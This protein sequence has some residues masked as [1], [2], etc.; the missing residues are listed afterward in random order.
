MIDGSV[1]EGGR[2][3]NRVVRALL[4]SICTN[5]L[6]MPTLGANCLSLDSY[7]AIIIKAVTWHYHKRQAAQGRFSLSR[8]SSLSSGV[9]DMTSTTAAAA[10]AQEIHVSSSYLGLLSAL[11]DERELSPRPQ[12]SRTLQGEQ[13]MPIRLASVDEE[14]GIPDTNWGGRYAHALPKLYIIV[15][16]IDGA[17]LQSV[18]SQRVLAALTEC[19]AISLIASADK[20]NAT[21]L[22]SNEMLDQYRWY[23]VHTPT[24]E[25]YELSRDFALLHGNKGTMHIQASSVETILN[26]LTMRHKE[27]FTLL[28]KE[29]LK[30]GQDNHNSRGVPFD[31]LLDQAM[32]AMLVNTSFG[33][34][35]YLK[36]FADHKV[37]MKSI[38]SNKREW[39]RITLPRTT[40][41]QMLQS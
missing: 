11:A 9:D 3:G 1:K 7:V 40:I 29:S 12:D 24:Y 23:F 19:P 35:N 13:A 2:T 20:L 33:L 17:A 36:E 10:S 27:L 32:K 28:A 34:N 18:E 16:A 26:S 4:D 31:Q 38:D 21:L 8:V 39:V 15:N 14:A 30:E 22:W 5:K 41:E 25:S 6:N 37:I